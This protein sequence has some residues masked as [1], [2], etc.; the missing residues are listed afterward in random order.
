MVSKDVSSSTLTSFHVSYADC[1]TNFQ[2]ALS[3]ARDTVKGHLEEYYF[4]QYD[5][6]EYVLLLSDDMQAF[7]GTDC[8]ASG[9]VAVVFWRQDVSVPRSE[10][11]SL[12]GT[13]TEV[14]ATPS[15][16]DVLLSGSVSAPDDVTSTW[17]IYQVSV[18][19]LHVYNSS[20]ICYSSVGEYQPKL[21]E[22]VSYYAFAGFV[23]ALGVIGFGL[24]DR[25]FRRIY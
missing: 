25:I 11:I 23:L 16:D 6:D 4:F 2:Y 1:D 8:S 22:G 9:V 12:Q 3:L 21:V 20:Y 24:V 5:D 7:N 19:S 18:D 13:I 17:S 15:V 14:G 10:S